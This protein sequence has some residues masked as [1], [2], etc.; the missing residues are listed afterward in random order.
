MR[1]GRETA[2]VGNGFSS[3]MLVESEMLIEHLR[4]QPLYRT[5]LIGQLLSDNSYRTTRPRAL[6]P[7][8]LMDALSNMRTQ[9]RLVLPVLLFQ[10][11]CASASR[12]VR[13]R[14]RPYL[15][16]ISQDSGALTVRSIVL[17]R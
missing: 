16:Y 8:T 11:R 4:H 13:R 12:R 7:E 15:V 6:R 17:Y 3:E 9:L 2:A 1:S 5:T 14:G 10:I